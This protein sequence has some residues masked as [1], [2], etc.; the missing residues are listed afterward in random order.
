MPV[1]ET[2][3]QQI[4]KHKS[5]P[6]SLHIAIPEAKGRDALLANMQGMMKALKLFLGQHAIM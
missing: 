3:G 5:V 6:E 4:G 1:G 2:S